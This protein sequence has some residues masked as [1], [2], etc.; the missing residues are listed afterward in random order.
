MTASF[1]SCDLV[2]FGRHTSTLREEIM[3]AA[4]IF[5]VFSTI[6]IYVITVIATLA[7]GANWPAVAIAD[8]QAMN[9]RTQF[10]VDFII[11]LLIVATWISW[12]EGFGVKG[13]TLGALSVVLGGMFTFPYLLYWTYKGGSDPNKILLGTRVT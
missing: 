3:T 4:R 7:Q 13:A 10:D 2:V 6:L 5:L 9:W 1:L 11:Y 12:R 8:L